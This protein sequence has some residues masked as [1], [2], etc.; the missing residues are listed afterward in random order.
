MS[1]Q[2]ETLTGK[3]V[4]HEHA[5]ADAETP[6][7]FYTQLFGWEL[8]EFGGNE[9]DYTMIKANGRSHGGFAQPEGG[10]PPHWVGYV[11]IEDAG[12]TAAKVKE[13]GGSLIMEPFDV[14]DVGRLSIAKDPQGAVFATIEPNMDAASDTPPPE[15]VFVWDELM[16]TDVEGAKAF[17][18][19]VFG[20]SS[21][22]ND[23]GRMTYT[24]FTRNGEGSEIGG[25]MPRREGVEIPSFWKPY[26]ATDDVDGTVEKAK[27]LGATVMAEPMDVPNVGRFAVLQD[28]QGAVFGLLAGS[29]Q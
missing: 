14:P 15:G 2:I 5:S 3:F 28:P 11:L 8:E 16:T 27:G 21:Y 26:I 18:A 12:E 25:C 4:W 1:T 9:M 23:M 10:A 29:G 13:A 22:D 24:L 20:W 6:K 7:A 17:Y 19:A